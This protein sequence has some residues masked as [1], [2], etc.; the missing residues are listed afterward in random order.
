MRKL[1]ILFMSLAGLS[2]PAP[3]IEYLTVESA[4]ILYDT[5]NAKTGTKLFVIRRDTPVEV[6]VNQGGWAKVRDAEGS[7]AWIERKELGTRRTLIVKADRATVLQNP[8]ESAPV[9][10]EAER[11]VSLDYLETLPGG[12]IKV[13]HRD[14]QEG[15]VRAGQIWGF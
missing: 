1:P 13:R 11:N 2:L 12:W 4:T 7:L 3:A 14:G 6:V 9:S 15:F 10:F 8:E 5:P